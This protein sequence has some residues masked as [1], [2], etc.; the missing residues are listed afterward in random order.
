M[1]N[2]I[3]SWVSKDRYEDLNDFYT[4]FLKQTTV[5]K[6]YLIRW[7]CP[8][9]KPI[10]QFDTFLKPHSYEY[11]VCNY[12]MLLNRFV[13]YDGK[14]SIELYSIDGWCII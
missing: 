11:M 14:D 10:N 12:S 2:C 8:N 7:L 1:N 9:K 4:D 13:S 3:V 5:S 6:T